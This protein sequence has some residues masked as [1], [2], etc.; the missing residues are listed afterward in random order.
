MPMLI[1]LLGGVPV[2]ANDPFVDLL[3]EDAVPAGVGVIVSLPRLQAEAETLLAGGRAV[4]VRLTADEPVEALEPYLDRLAT[5]ALEFPKFRDGR[6]FSAANLLRQRYGYRGE[7]RAVG[8]VVRE[9]ARFM[10]RCGM[11]AYI[12]ADG[13]T[14]EQ[15]ATSIGRFRHV[16][17]T[18]ADGLT[19]VFAE[20]AGA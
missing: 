20:R 11:D 19:P 18:A 5:V 17:Q 14:P 7:V 16:Y 10:V 8:A 2:A 6:A 13:S 4:G 15:W 3:D 9:S 12:P 1:K